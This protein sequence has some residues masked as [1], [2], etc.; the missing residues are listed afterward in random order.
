MLTGRC[1]FDI[2]CC[3]QKNV[4]AKH[5]EMGGELYINRKI[6]KTKAHSL[7][8]TLSLIFLSSI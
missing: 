3:V 1:T 4:W 6:T 8:N 7:G 2:Y 5:R